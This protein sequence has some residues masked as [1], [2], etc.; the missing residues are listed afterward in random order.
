MTSSLSWYKFLL[1]LRPKNSPAFKSFSESFSFFQPLIEMNFSIHSG[2][3][4]ESFWKVIFAISFAV[5]KEA[6]EIPWE[7]LGTL[8]TTGT[9]R[10]R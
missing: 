5:A 4:V 3:E 2:K 10:Y 1:N 7:K 8:L 6:T 9:V